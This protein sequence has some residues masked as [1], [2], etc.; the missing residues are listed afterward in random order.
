MKLAWGGGS[1][2]NGIF[3]TTAENSG[4]TLNLDKPGRKI[5]HQFVSSCEKH[6]VSLFF[7]SGLNL[8]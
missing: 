3:T 8:T 7:R 5:Y 4:E 2:C 6:F 1:P